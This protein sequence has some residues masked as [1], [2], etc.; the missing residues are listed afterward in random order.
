MTLAVVVGCVTQLS[1]QAHVQ[2]EPQIVE[3]VVSPG[4]T[5]E[6]IIKFTNA[7]TATVDVAVELA[8]FDASEEGNAVILPLGTSDISLAPYLKVTPLASA[9]GARSDGSLPA[10]R[11]APRDV[12]SPPR[13]AVLH[14]QSRDSS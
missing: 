8:D 6:E 4:G 5:F 9:C 14:S 12:R 13:H 3:Q 10:R 1:A 7:G 11:Q 2:I